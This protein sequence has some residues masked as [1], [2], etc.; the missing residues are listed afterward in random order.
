M[1]FEGRFL[2]FR[3]SV[4]ASLTVMGMRKAACHGR[5]GLRND[6]LFTKCIDYKEKQEGG[7]LS[8]RLGAH[9]LMVLIEAS[10]G[11]SGLVGNE[12]GNGS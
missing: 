7:T 6:I 10:R 8:Y 11:T 3:S 1:H 12:T 4:L 5:C 9:C 2:A